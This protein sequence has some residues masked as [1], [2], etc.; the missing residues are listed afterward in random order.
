MLNLKNDVNSREE[1][2][3]K[4]QRV[5]LYGAGAAAKLLLQSYYEIFPQESV[6]FIVDGNPELDG[7]DCVVNEHLRI[8]IVSLTHFCG[9]WSEK[10]RQ[11]TFLFTPYYSL[12]F[13]SQLDQIKELDQAEAYIYPFLAEKTPP[14]EFRL[15]ETDRPR[16]PKV[17][18]YIWLGGALPEEYRRNIDSWKRFCPDYEIVEWNESN[19][20]FGKYQYVREALEN[21]QYMYATDAARKDILYTYGGI[22]FDTDVEILKPIDDL[23][24]QEAF[25]GIDDGGQLNSGSGLGAVKHNE[26]IREM[27]ELYEKE[28]FVKADGSFN[29]TYNT[30]YETRLLIEKG[31]RVRNSYQKIG[32][33]NCLPREVLMPE[34]V[35]GLRNCYTKNTRAH[36]KINPY[37]KKEIAAVQDRLYSD[38]AC[39]RQGEDR[40]CSTTLF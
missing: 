5:V 16:I 29:R 37:N 38:Q 24:Y 15:R 21:R 40:L 31:F 6:E 34:G 30:F 8:K 35:V 9:I 26:I 4:K 33:M 2:F 12:F 32:T 10:V 22:Y 14:G 28:V 27:L 3:E 17:I 13:I 7:T 36:H 20:D 23:L 11:F 39:S 18:H 1:L 25:I 19:Y